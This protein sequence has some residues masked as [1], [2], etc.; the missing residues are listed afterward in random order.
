MLEVWLGILDVLDRLMGS[1]A[2]QGHGERGKGGAEDGGL[3]EQIPESLKNILLVM[4]GAGYL[5]PPEQGSRPRREEA[6]RTQGE[7]EAT[8]QKG[9][10]EGGGAGREEGKVDNSVRIWT[11]TKKRVHR[12]LPGVFDE[13][14]P[15]PP[16][17]PPPS[18]S[19]APPLSRQQQ[20]KRDAD[21]ED[22]K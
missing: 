1:G 4:G 18:S 16:P 22:T 8:A 11:E 20:Q 21:K 3:E 17:P 2:Q 15:P 6:S 13:V 12:F 9:N 14:F 19:S 7:E 5:R 10:E